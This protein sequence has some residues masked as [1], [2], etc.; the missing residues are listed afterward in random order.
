MLEHRILFYDSNPLNRKTGIRI[1]SATG[2]DGSYPKTFD[3]LVE[4][5]ENHPF[6]LMVFDLLTHRELTAKG[7]D[8]SEQNVVILSNEKMRDTSSYLVNLP[9]FNNFIA[10]DENCAFSNREVLTTTKKIL[11]NDIFGVQKYLSWG[12]SSMVFHIRDSSQRQEHIDL[13]LEYCRNMRLREPII[14][15][16]QSISE[17]FLMNAIYDAP[18]DQEGNE[19]YSGS[20]RT[21]RILLSPKNSARFEIASDGERLAVSVSDPF[22]GLTRS[23]VLEYLHRC[24]NSPLAKMGPEE[25]GG[26]GL[27]LFLCFNSVSTF[28]INN[29]I[30]SIINSSCM[31]FFI[32]KCFY[33]ICCS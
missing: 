27:G 23:T 28:I 9:N 30:K 4:R 24:F 6:S 20:S 1:L 13:A 7:I 14:K 32:Q 12:A 21:E 29:Q 3:E 8:L 15:A 31:I 16:V 5:I 22:G 11:N 18:R 26:A 17:E 19:L 25:K 10:K 2:E 33:Y